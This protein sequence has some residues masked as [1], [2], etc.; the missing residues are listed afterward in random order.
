MKR[1]IPTSGTIGSAAL[2]VLLVVL[3]LSLIG[4]G[5][6]MA[7]GASGR[8]ARA[9][10]DETALEERLSEAVRRTLSILRE[11]PTPESDS[12]NDPVWAELR[13]L[14]TKVDLRDVSSRIN[15]NTIR[16]TLLDRTGLD[17][18]IFADSRAAGSDAL[19]QYREDDW[20]STDIADH[21]GDFFSDEALDELVTGYGW[22]NIN[23]TD[24]FVLR[25]IYAERT[26][27][28]I[29]AQHFRGLAVAI[30]GRDTMITRE[31]LRGYLGAD[32][33]RV[34]PVVNAEPL[35]NVHYLPERI[36]R[37]VLSYPALGVSDPDGVAAALVALRVSSSLSMDELT[38]RTG[39]PESSRLH[40]YLGVRTWFWKIGAQVSDLR[41]EIVAARIPGESPTFQIVERRIMRRDS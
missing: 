29:G 20:L 16:P 8:L 3:L 10:L 19:R 13:D 11:D 14:E 21:Y 24:E 31:A 6:V 4:G 7:L 9:V 40:Q 18:L 27:N 32:F 39:L 33:D 25:S 12:P 35:W 41:L 28:D 15:P 1:R 23:V 37:E 26:G 36:L 30:I 34:Y 17:D 22:A 5:A 2:S 38:E